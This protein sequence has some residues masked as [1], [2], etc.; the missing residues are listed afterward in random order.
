MSKHEYQ[1]LGQAGALRC[2]DLV[3]G[4]STRVDL[5]S[6]EDVVREGS[7]R[8]DESDAEFA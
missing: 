3:A 8:G 1:A 4:E 6:D 7:A 2:H 5:L